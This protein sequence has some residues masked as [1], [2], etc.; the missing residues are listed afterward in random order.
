MVMLYTQP[1]CAP[2]AA[3]KRMLVKL[4]VEHEVL[5]VTQ[6]PE[7]MRIVKDL[8]YSSAPVVVVDEDEHW[9]GFRPSRIEALAARQ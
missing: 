8:G 5:D 3:T 4:D 9:S 1:G 2:C 6:H 7:A